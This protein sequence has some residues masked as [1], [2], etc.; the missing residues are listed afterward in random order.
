M[1]FEPEVLQRLEHEAAQAKVGLSTVIEGHIKADW[2]H[3]TGEQTMLQARMDQL[4]ADL[5]DLR[6]KVLPLVATVTAML[7]QMEGELPVKPETEA[8]TPEL[9]IATYEEMYGPMNQAAPSVNPASPPNP[10]TIEEEPKPRKGW[11]W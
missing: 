4:A 2:Q 3:A 11:L 8:A 5:A 7:R 10:P 6:A 1:T 9:R